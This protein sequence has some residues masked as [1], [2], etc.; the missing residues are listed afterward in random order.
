MINGI[1]NLFMT[2][3][4]VLSGFKTIRVCTAY[5][6]DGKICHELPFDNETAIEPVYTEFEGWNEDIKTIRSFNKLPATLKK[7][8]DFIENETG[9]PVTIVSVGPDREETIFRD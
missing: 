4:D 2:K 3:A 8:I 5:K 6:I 9:V 1:T 7:Y